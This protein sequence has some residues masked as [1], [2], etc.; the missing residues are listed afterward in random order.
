MQDNYDL[1]AAE[2]KPDESAGT[3]V[4]DTNAGDA[5]AA[6]RN[7]IVWPEDDD[8]VQRYESGSGRNAFRTERRSFREQVFI[9]IFLTGFYE[10]A[11]RESQARLYLEDVDGISDETRD[12]I[13]AKYAEVASRIGRID[14]M[15]SKASQGWNLHRIGKAELN[16][17]RVAVY[18]M[19]FDDE[20]PVSVAINEAVEL[21]RKYGVDQS[22]AF[23]NGILSA[24]LKNNPVG[25]PKPK[26]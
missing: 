18:E 5:N 6:D 1:S 9:L 11:D 7:E 19:Y 3:G 4:G 8:S 15:I 17:L 2:T 25:D 26:A 12:R 21:A 13:Y 20:V 24:V 10:K 23:V 16:I 14:P 22:H